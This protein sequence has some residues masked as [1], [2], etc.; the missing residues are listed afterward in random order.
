ME[1][2]RLKYSEVEALLSELHLVSPQGRVA[3][4]GRIKNFQKKGWPRRVKA[5]RGKPAEYSIRAVVELLLAFELTTLRIP[6]EQAVNILIGLDW[7]PVNED[8]AELGHRMEMG[9]QDGTDQMGRVLSTPKLLVFDPDGLSEIRQEG[10]TGYNVP[11]EPP[12]IA[13]VEDGD[14]E[15]LSYAGRRFASVNLTRLFVFAASISEQMGLVVI[16]QF[17][18]H[19]QTLVDDD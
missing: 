10:R 2:L 1:S 9:L 19:L 6:P 15:D 11:G 18:L 16:Q 17:G 5:G 4:M 8:L 13:N 3:L 14:L 7:G 12:W